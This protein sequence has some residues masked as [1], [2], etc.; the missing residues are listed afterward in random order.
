[1]DAEEKREIMNRAFRSMVALLASA[2]ALT[3]LA[4]A[5]RERAAIRTVAE[6]TTVTF[7][8]RSHANVFFVGH[9]LIN[10]EMPKNMEVMA[11]SLGLELEWDAQIID[12]APLQTHVEHPERTQSMR[13]DEA[14]GSGFYD[15]LIMTEAVPI[16]DMIRYREPSRYA[17]SLAKRARR[18]RSDARVFLHEVWVH[19]DRPRGSPFMRR[20]DWRVFLDEDLPKWE[21]IADDA[22]RAAAAPIAVL[23]AA[24]ALGRLVD[25]LHAGEVPG[26]VEGDLFADHVHLT[27]LGNHFIAAVTLAAV[28]QR[29]PMGASGEVVDRHG[30][31]VLTLPER[32]RDVLYGLAW[33]AV[34]TYPRANTPSSWIGASARNVTGAP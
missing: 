29:T 30:R 9:S 13:V 6:S 27:P 15:T 33:T 18:D 17:A 31:R 7:T 20:L 32:T 3:L 11:K 25:A 2:A 19:R 34:A 10:F 1:M 23:P 26:L 14:L 12:G 28:F 21:R 8:A 16:D 24:R 4:S 5:C 22:S